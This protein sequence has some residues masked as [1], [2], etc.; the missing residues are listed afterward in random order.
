[1]DD[2]EFIYITIKFQGSGDYTVSPEKAVDI[3]EVS[4]L[5]NISC[6]EDMMSL[7]HHQG[8]DPVFVD[9]HY[10]D[11]KSVVFKLRS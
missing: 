9:W 2:R 11:I 7:M 1:M 5:D 6:P 4:H 10:G 8:Y 3:V